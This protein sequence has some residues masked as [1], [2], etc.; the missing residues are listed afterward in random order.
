MT[1]TT[2]K[3]IVT[4]FVSL[5]GVME[6]PGGAEGFVHGGWSM[7]FNDPVGMGFK[8]QE[9]LDAGALLL[10]RTTYEGFAAAWPGRD[11][12]AG[13]AAKMNAMPKIVVSTTLTD[14]T[15]ENT[16]VISDD[17]VNQVAALKQTE[18][19]PI[20]VAG[21]RTLVHTL[22]ENDLVDQYNLLVAP[23]VLG[24][25]KRLFD[26]TGDTQTLELVES[27]PL[28]SGGLWL[29]YQPKR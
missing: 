25:G 1:T 12:E 3:I 18:G 16:T 17:V 7:K 9:T 13:F 23:I 26:D 5:D 24:T 22:R 2:R 19:D 4:E 28:G 20:L 11:D 10:G 6:D 8:L 14:P 21:S 15:W 29:I 27:T